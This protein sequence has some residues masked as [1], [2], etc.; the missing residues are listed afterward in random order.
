MLKFSDQLDELLSRYLFLKT[1]L[2]R[3]E[4]IA[5]KLADSNQT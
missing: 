3:N 1:K 2:L 5:F 4:K